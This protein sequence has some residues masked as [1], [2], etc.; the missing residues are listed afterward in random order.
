MHRRSL[1]PPGSRCAVGKGKGKSRAS[2]EQLKGQRATSRRSVVDPKPRRD[3]I[4]MPKLVTKKQAAE[5]I[6][7]AYQSHVLQRFEFL[8][9]AGLQ[10]GGKRD[11]WETAGYEKAPTFDHYWNMYKRDAI[12]GRIVDMAPKTT[13]R[14]PPFI[15]EEGQ[16]ETTFTK[17]FDALATKLKLWRYFER[18]DR[19]SGVGRYGILLIGTRGSEDMK[20]PLKK[21]SGPDSVIYL[22]AYHEGNAAINTWVTDTNDPRFGQPES[23]KVTLTSGIDNFK[24]SGQTAQLIVHWSRIIHVAED[25]LEDEVFGRPRLE[26]ALNRLADLDKIAASTGEGYWQSVV[27]ILTANVAPE[28]E[29]S[30]PDFK[31][32]DERLLEMT[33]DLRRQFT[34]QGVKLEWL[35]S[36]I[37]TVKDIGDFYFALIAGAVGIPQRILFGSEMGELASTTD[38]QS[39]FGL[40]NERQE[41][42]AEPSI[43]RAF[44]DRMIEFNVL[45]TPSSGEYQVQW[46]TLFETTDTE[47]AELNLKVAQQAQTL[48]PVGGDPRTMVTIDD[49]GQINLIP[50]D[51]D[52]VE[53]LKDE[54]LLGAPEPGTIPEPGAPGAEPKPGDEPP[55]VGLNEPPVPPAQGENDVA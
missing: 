24:P 22:Q 32:L 40:I 8:Q 29:M 51:E 2:I 44:I 30:E 46:Q 23:Y 12:G 4:K 54:M 10:Y 34:G 5:F 55:P 16:E 42:F 47:N 7:R 9:R 27:R 21:L 18:V 28:A 41:Q 38:Q 31:K 33:H 35:P 48:T 20:R 36:E 52:D 15:V 19:L 39:W 1:P 3:G 50:Q 14:T 6:R 45:P 37:P 13:W 25:L 17:A 49:E 11:I 43:L 26:R 53:E